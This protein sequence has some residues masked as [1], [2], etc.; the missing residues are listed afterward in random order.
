MPTAAR[1]GRHPGVV[2]VV[3]R[4]AGGVPLLGIVLVIR[5]HRCPTRRGRASP[6]GG[7]GHRRTPFMPA[8]PRRWGYARG[9]RNTFSAV[10]SRA[11]YWSLPGREISGRSARGDG[12]ASTCGH[13]GRR[14]AGDDGGRGGDRGGG[15]HRGRRSATGASAHSA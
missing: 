14:G 2:V 6:V 11:Y 7:G 12:R 13:T 8:A 1:P 10:L 5:H 15:R 3:G 9:R 4:G